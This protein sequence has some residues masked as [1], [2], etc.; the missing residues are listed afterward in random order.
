[1]P[2]PRP[3]INTLPPIHH[4]APDYAELE[5]LGFSP[6]EI[7][8]FSVNSNPYGPSPEVRH[9]LASVPLERY[10]DRESLA[11]RR[12][13]AAHHGVSL[14]SILPTNGTAEL[15]WLIALAYLRPGD[16]VLLLGPT[17][18]EYANA[19]AI[20]GAD[21]HTWIALPEDHFAFQPDAITR[22]LDEVY[23]RLVFLCTPNNPTGQTLPSRVLEGWA[24]RYAATLFVVD[25]AYLAFA[26]DIS[27]ALEI[28]QPNVLVMRSMTKDYALAGLRLGY[29]VGHERI[30]H[31]LRKTQPPWSVNAM[32]QAAGLAAL[33]AL[34]YYEHCWQKIRHH[35]A[36]FT[37]RLATAGFP[38]IPSETHFF[39]LP[40]KNGAKFRSKLMK[41]GIQVRDCASFG[42]P[43]YVRIAT[44]L[45]EEN[46]RFLA[47]FLGPRETRFKNHEV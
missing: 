29:A 45:P 42:L 18:G 7:L 30:I 15:I 9:A 43:D 46:E 20:M 17:F 47:A 14:Q 36:E 35:K 4:G 32:A 34:A 41:K 12:A 6:N 33:N 25:E 19:S 3:P 39:L 21:V 23:Y 40:V 10:P 38:P 44:R 22:Q 26:A 1:M 31:A 2:T 8:D 37:A 5:R 28:D 24:D 13:V 16:R 27:S 11:L